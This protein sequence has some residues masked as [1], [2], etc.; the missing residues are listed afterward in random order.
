MHNSNQLLHVDEKIVVGFQE[1][2]ALVLALEEF[3]HR[4][5]LECQVGV[6]VDEVLDDDVSVFEVFGHDDF[7]RGRGVPGFAQ[8]EEQEGVGFGEAVW[9][10]PGAA[11]GGS[12]RLVSWVRVDE[13]E[14]GCWGGAEVGEEVFDVEVYVEGDVSGGGFGPGVQRELCVPAAK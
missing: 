5:R 7:A 6:V 9:V 13:D 2:P 8:K 4:H 1:K 14:E 3:E 11:D 10:A 12:C